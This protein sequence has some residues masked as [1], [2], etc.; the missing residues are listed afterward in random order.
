MIHNIAETIK[1][2]KKEGE[3]ASQV[4]WFVQVAVIPKKKGVVF[5]CLAYPTALKRQLLSEGMT[6]LRITPSMM[7]IVDKYQPENQSQEEKNIQNLK[8]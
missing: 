8:R 2:K 6:L 7:Q 3:R 1:N 4:E 5:H